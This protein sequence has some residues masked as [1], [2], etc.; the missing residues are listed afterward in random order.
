MSNFLGSSDR[1]APSL[2]GISFNIFT[3]LQRL[4]VKHKT[5]FLFLKAFKEEIASKNWEKYSLPCWCYVFYWY[6]KPLG[7]GRQ[8]SW[9]CSSSPTSS[10]PCISAPWLCSVHNEQRTS[11]V[12]KPNFAQAELCS[13]TVLAYI[14]TIWQT[15]DR[16]LLTPDSESSK[17]IYM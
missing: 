16:T 7:R 17:S 1:P 5:P 15:I 6:L 12:C 10:R 9:T 8:M 2:R 3:Y 4:T 11:A 13:Y 14:D